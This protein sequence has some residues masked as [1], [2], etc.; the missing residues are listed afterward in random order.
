MK[1]PLFS[2]TFIGLTLTSLISW[3][4]LFMS[5]G[6]AQSITTL[7]TSS[8]EGQ[9]AL[10]EVCNQENI[11]PIRFSRSRGQPWQ[12][13]ADISAY[14]QRSIGEVILHCE[15][16]Q[17][18]DERSILELIR[19]IQVPRYQRI[20]EQ[21][22]E[23]SWSRM[24]ALGFFE[25]ESFFILEDT[26][27]ASD[28]E[29]ITLRICA[30]SA[31]IIESIEIHYRSWMSALYP[32]Q[33][34]SEIQKRLNLQ[35]GGRLPRS[36]QLLR[37]Q[38]EQLKSSYTR[39][40]YQNVQVSLIPVYQ[41]EAKRR[42]KLEVHV[43]EG[44][45]PRL[46]A[47]L[48]ELIDQDLSQ[49]ELVSEHRRITRAIAPDL[50]YDV[51]E[52]F[53]SIFGIGHYDRRETRQRADDFE[54]EIRE[55]GWVSA[56]VKVIGDELFQEKM[57]PVITLKRGPKLL[58][59]FEGHQAISTQQLERVLTFKESG[60]ID[61]VELEASRKNIVDLFK[62]ASYYYVKVESSLRRLENDDRGQI[63][64]KFIIDEGPQV[65][66][67]QVITR[68]VSS[69]HLDDLSKV[70]KSRG[71]A[72]NGV[73]G[74]FGASSGILQEATLRQDLRAII[75]RYRSLGY[76][77]VSLR[78]ASPDSSRLFRAE[79]S[80]NLSSFDLWSTDI[81]SHICYR[82]I[83]DHKVRAQRRLLTLL[84]EVNEGQ[85]TRL[86][87]ADFYPF[88]QTMD[89]QRADER[90]NLLR[91]LELI[92]DLG[93][94]ITEAGFSQDKLNLLSNFLLLSL[95]ERGYLRA[96]VQPMCQ[97]K[98]GRAELSEPKL[99][100]LE[101]LYGQVI[102]RLSFTAE[103]GPK[104]EV[105]GLL[106]HGQ[107]LTKEEVIRREILLKSGQ[108]LSAEALLL[109][110]SNLRGLG[111]FRSVTLKPIGLGAAPQTS[112]V[113]PVTLV[114]NVEENLPWLLDGYFGLRLTDEAITTDLQGLN[115]LYTSALTIRHR[116]VTGRGWELGGGVSHDNLLFNPTDIEGDNASWAIGP[117]F[118]NPRLFDSYIQ[119]FSE[120]IFEQGLSTQRTSYLQRVRGKS[121]LSYNFYNLSFPERWGQ[122]LT[123]ELELEAKMER[124]RPLTRYSERRAFSES[125]P[126]FNFAPTIV[127][128]QRDNPIHPT[129][130]FY[131]TAG[132]D[133]LGSQQLFEGVISYKETLSAQW[134]GN[135]FRRQLLFV[136]TIKLGAVQS[137]L[138]DS[139]LTLSSADFLFSAGGDG[140]I[141]PVRG[142]PIAVINTCTKANRTLGQCDTLG[143]ALTPD[144]SDLIN[145]AGRAI[146]NMSV[147]ARFPSFILS[148]LWLATFGDLGAV[149]DGLTRFDTHSFYP[150]IG[151][152]IRYLLP[153]QV[154]L[155]FDIAYPLR[156]TAF[157]AQSLGYHFNFFYVL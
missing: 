34:L 66:L 77:K 12:I 148:K 69:P 139:Q 125:T 97:L 86:N 32:K 140:V 101:E 153:G 117:F 128:D 31:P 114:L 78:C 112:I 58:T 132:V 41:D 143:E 51:F 19:F 109:S 118:K 147:E 68:G 50:F 6:F 89:Q 54:R 74:T 82:V 76:S 4:L 120:L 113:E 103:L 88:D 60:V 62:S 38:E 39:L 115:L 137:S 64:A 44:Q 25:P 94:P 9:R 20:N 33:F 85:R 5:S 71:V 36:S 146:I 57:S 55:H 3:L 142:Y 119:L 151:G 104:A 28:E 80:P 152:G 37:R 65:Y 108:P 48:I 72:A 99:C 40:G 135:W 1:Q 14:S 70:I 30:L 15:I 106:I 145:F 73:I 81:N 24:M 59:T 95:K 154:P 84:I 23:A 96:K 144:P 7:E 141:Y 13:K 90:D 27:L 29:P 111:L 22:L 26:M 53:F 100:N 110:Q 122:G 79:R 87:F 127:Y 123:F 47:P 8:N 18:A 10:G 138:T 107:L 35:R 21:D 42:V 61:E 56:R 136:P 124:Q 102:E 121:T 129:R 150:S 93:Q 52:D 116:N 157:S 126:S 98:V 156:E 91:G 75:Q 46:G 105:N 155:R 130:G 49:E 83:S 16:S 17:C 2:S 45:R 131:L 133:F 92:D 63:E 134:V 67:S 149:S 43:Q 11:D